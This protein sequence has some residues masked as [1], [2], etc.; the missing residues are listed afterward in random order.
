[1][2]VL[3]EEME[4]SVD[5]KDVDSSLPCTARLL[6]DIVWR[7]SENNSAVV[8]SISTSYRTG[9]ETCRFIKAFHKSSVGE[10]LVFTLWVLVESGSAVS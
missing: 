9:N 7:S 8:E 3:N 5:V 2:A 6:D 4:Y 10:Y 1:M